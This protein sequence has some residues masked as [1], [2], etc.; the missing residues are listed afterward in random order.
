MLFSLHID[1]ICLLKKHSILNKSVEFN[2]APDQATIHE[3]TGYVEQ[4]GVEKSFT[5]KRDF[6]RLSIGV[7]RF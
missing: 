6:V 3:V 7:R 1:E 2:R 5:F 4:S